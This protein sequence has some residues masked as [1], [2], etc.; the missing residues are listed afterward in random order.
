MFI[1][2]VFL[3]E[4]KKQKTKNKKQ[5]KEQQRDDGKVKYPLKESFYSVALFADV[6][7]FTKLTERLAKLGPLGCELLAKHLNAYLI[8]IGIKHSNFYLFFLQKKKK[9][10]TTFAKNKTKV[11]LILSAG[12]DV[13]KFAGDA[14]ICVWPPPMN[15]KGD[16][17]VDEVKQKDTAKA[18]LQRCVQARAIF[19]FSFLFFAC[20]KKKKKKRNKKSKIGCKKH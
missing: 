19:F 11:R 12:G 20:K 15:E 16:D 5:N 4:N 8:Q 1:F 18:A 3:K 2:V 10:K 14:L 13:V 7:G 17:W 6:S 9:T